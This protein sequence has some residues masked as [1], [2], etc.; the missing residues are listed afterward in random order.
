MKTKKNPGYD[1]ENKKRVFFLLGLVISLGVILM[2]LNVETRPQPE[3]F[4][5]TTHVFT[6]EEYNVQLIREP[7]PAVPPQMK[8]A[9]II[10]LIDDNQPVETNTDNFISEPG[11]NPVYEYPAS[12]KELPKEETDDNT[13]YISPQQ[14]PEFPGGNAALVRFL[15]S[16]VH[17]PLVALQNETEGKVFVSFVI[18]EAGKVQN[19]EVI[20]GIDP[21]LDAE[22]LRVVGLMPDW[23]PGKQGG[24]AVKVRYSVPILFDLQ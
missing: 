21:L 3:K 23:K 22:A 13:I 20:R 18:N 14:M 1:L 6:D 15:A 7:K 10:R 19:I 4:V 11:D 17:Y 5:G 8:I 9:P 16:N 24:K 2:A 12:V